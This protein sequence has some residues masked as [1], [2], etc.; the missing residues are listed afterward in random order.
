MYDVIIIGG[1]IAGLYSA[2]K[3]LKNNPDTKLLILESNQIGGRIGTEMFQGVRVVTGAGIGRKN[4]DHLLIQLL[5]DL[6]IPIKTFPSTHHYANISCDVKK[7]FNA[8]KKRFNESR[9]K[10]T[11][12]EFAMPL[13]GP[14]Y[15]NFVVCAGYTDYENEDAYET[16]YNYGF[17]DN[18]NNWTAISVPW[19]ELIDKLVKKVGRIRHA[20]VTRLEYLNHFFVYTNK[21]VYH[22][23]KIILNYV[24]DQLFFHTFLLQLF[25]NHN[26]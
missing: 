14:A 8:L 11:F 4:K 17:D 2:Y 24:F 15:K 1:G 13:L 21:D 23:H 22:C 7:T 25:L 10:K 9:P 18:F 3:I 5:K 19:S 16:F 20:K 26:N 6:K 12:K